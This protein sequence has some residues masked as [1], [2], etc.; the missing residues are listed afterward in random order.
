MAP[1]MVGS[2]CAY[3]SLFGLDVGPNHLLER[4]EG[5]LSARDTA[6]AFAGTLSI[7]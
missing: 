7:L 5:E 2:N 6:G 3:L 1:R 4:P